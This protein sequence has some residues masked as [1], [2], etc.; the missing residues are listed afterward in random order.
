MRHLQSSGDVGFGTRVLVGGAGRWRPLFFFVGILPKVWGFARFSDG[1]TGDVTLHPTTPAGD[2]LQAGAG[3]Q[4]SAA[5]G[6][7]L[8]WRCSPGWGWHGDDL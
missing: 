8:G 7:E 5:L 1:T 6:L 4:M 2:E 3:T